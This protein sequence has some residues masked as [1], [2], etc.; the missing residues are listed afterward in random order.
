MRNLSLGNQVTAVIPAYNVEEYLDET[1]KSLMEQTLPLQG[2]IIVNDNSS[3]RTPDKCRSWEERFLKLIKVVNQTVNCGASAARN[4]GVDLAATEWILFMDADDIA[5]GDLLRK[6]LERIAQLQAEWGEEVALAYSAYSQ[7]SGTGKPMLGVHRSRQMAPEEILGYELIRNQIITTSGVLVKKDF[8]QKAGGFDIGLK[9]S[10]DWDLWLRLAQ[11]GGF[12][13]VDEPLVKVRRHTNNLSRNLQSMLDGEKAVLGRYSAP[14]IEQAIMKRRLPWEVNRTDQVS[15]LYRIGRWEEGFAIIQAVV[16]ACP[17]FSEGY[18]QMGLYYLSKKEWEKAQTTFR[19]ALALNPEHG[20]AMNN[21][22]AVTALNG[23][24]QQVEALFA[25]ALSL[26][27]NY[28]DAQHN[29]DT[30]TVT[31]HLKPSE[32]RFTWRRLR[33]VL[34]QYLEK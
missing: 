31:G 24:N 19:Q 3:D 1:L 8:F 15:V 6:E 33:A 11:L 20:A 2:I 21:L 9:Y 4:L 26:H 18:F 29:L 23:P 22:A 5:V 30:L 16:E 13:Y 7:I 25:K 34:T 32:A 10:E 17:E 14:F 27:P 28:L 12:A